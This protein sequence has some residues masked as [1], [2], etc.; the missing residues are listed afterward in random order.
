MNSQNYLNFRIMAEEV[1]GQEETLLRELNSS[2][3]GRPVQEA[4]EASLHRLTHWLEECEASLPEARQATAEAA[5]IV[6]GLASTSMRATNPALDRDLRDLALSL[7]YLDVCQLR[8]E[9]SNGEMER[10]TSAASLVLDEARW[11]MA[12]VKGPRFSLS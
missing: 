12:A 11:A 1:A 4:V 2:G 8:A 10:Q 3:T 9:S 5:A 7:L 6:S